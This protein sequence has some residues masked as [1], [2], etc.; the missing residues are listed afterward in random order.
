MT[1]HTY[2]VPCDQCRGE[3]CGKCDGGQ[4]I[5]RLPALHPA[6]RR[7]DASLIVSVAA[8]VLLGLILIHHFGFAR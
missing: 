5:M 4:I 1:L 3:G 8:L 6:T 2:A 7:V